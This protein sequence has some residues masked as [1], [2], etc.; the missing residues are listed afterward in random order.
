LFTS[1]IY[2]R[3][4]VSKNQKTFLWKV[5][6]KTGTVYVLGSIHLLKKES[7]PLNEKIEN[8]FDKSN[9]LVVEANINDIGQIDVQKLI[10]SVLYPE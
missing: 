4:A 3:D 7:Y 1:S 8:A 10:E 2:A 5:Q 9:V 6:S